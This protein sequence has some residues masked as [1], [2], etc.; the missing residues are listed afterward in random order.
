MQLQA[1]CKMTKDFSIQYSCSFFGHDA[2][3]MQVILVRHVGF[4]VHIDFVVH[5]R[6]VLKAATMTSDDA[7]ESI[8]K[9]DVDVD[10]TC[11]NAARRMRHQCCHHEAKP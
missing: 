8:D 3:W 7:E 9:K 5:V 1:K 4:V 2:R 11:T 6:L 10:D